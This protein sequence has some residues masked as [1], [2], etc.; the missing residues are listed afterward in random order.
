MLKDFFLNSEGTLF[1][2]VR[3]HWEHSHRSDLENSTLMFVKSLGRIERSMAS[4]IDKSQ[5]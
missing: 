5:K 2:K 3:Y 4:K 1:F